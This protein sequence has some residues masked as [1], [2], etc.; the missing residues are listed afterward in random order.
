LDAYIAKRRRGLTLKNRYEDRYYVGKK[1]FTAAGPYTYI[2]TTDGSLVCFEMRHAPPK[3]KES[4]ICADAGQN[5]GQFW[6]I[7]DF[8]VE[9]LTNATAEG[10]V[11]ADGNDK[12]GSPIPS[13][14]GTAATST[15]IKF[16]IRNS[17]TG[18][19]L[20]CER[21]YDGLLLDGG[22]PEP[23]PEGVDGLKAE[24]WDLMYCENPWNELHI[25][26]VSYVSFGF[27]KKYQLLYIDTVWDCHPLKFD[28]SIG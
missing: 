26:S 22:D 18:L 13:S 16:R 19:E 6:L 14:D 24:T 11:D 12:I 2:N 15:I 21:A 25:T 4:D 10:V 9:T 8:L 5:E 17:L 20:T 3:P 28:H 1:E 27:S 7:S 23:L